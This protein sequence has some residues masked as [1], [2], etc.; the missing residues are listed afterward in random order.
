MYIYTPHH[1]HTPLAIKMV[2]FSSMQHKNIS[3]QETFT[4]TSKGIEIYGGFIK[5]LFWKTRVSNTFTMDS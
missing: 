3:D 2:N 5:K 4:C 1:T